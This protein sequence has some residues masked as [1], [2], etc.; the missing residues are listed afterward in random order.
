MPKRI[1]IDLTPEQSK[2]LKGMSNI[3]GSTLKD[4]LTHIVVDVLAEE[5]RRQDAAKKAPTLEQIIDE[6]RN[7]DHPPQP[8]TPRRDPATR[9]YC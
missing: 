6:L 4:R 5:K 8:I 2:T 3:Y 7:A 9:F 1:T